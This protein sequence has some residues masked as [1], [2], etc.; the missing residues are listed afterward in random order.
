MGVVVADTTCRHLHRRS[1][2]LCS[3]MSVLP[4]RKSAAGWRAQCMRG[5]ASDPSGSGKDAPH[6][7]SDLAFRSRLSCP[8]PGV[9]NRC[10]GPRV[11]TVDAVPSK[12]HCVRQEDRL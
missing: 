3:A 7:I 12:T 5:G 10:G 2:C 9:S 8:S 11:T 6:P 1:E 4:G